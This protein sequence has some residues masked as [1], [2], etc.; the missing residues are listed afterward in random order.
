M[1]FFKNLFG[2]GPKVDLKSLVFEEKA[3]ILDVRSPQ[4][5][6]G[7]HI[8]S[9]VNIPLQSVSN[10]KSLPDDKNRPIITC[11]ASGRRSG[12]AKSQLKSK[13]YTNVHNG[14]GWMALKSKLQ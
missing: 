13:G 11:C 10:S 8:K 7:G 2:S 9:A 14:G 6:K 3:L 1:S 12:I 5:F 4:E